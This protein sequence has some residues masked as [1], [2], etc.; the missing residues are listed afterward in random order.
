MFLNLTSFYF[1]LF[2]SFLYSC[3][4]NH[5]RWSRVSQLVSCKTSTW[6]MLLLLCQSSWATFFFTWDS[7]WIFVNIQ[8]TVAFTSWI[9]GWIWLHLSCFEDL[10]RCSWH[11]RC[12]NT[13]ILSLEMYS[14]L[15]LSVSWQYRSWQLFSFIVYFNR[16]S[17]Q[18]TLTP[19]LLLS[20]KERQSSQ[21]M[22]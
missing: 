13:R 16:S 5:N 7:C 12:C 9:D 3:L 6:V 22:E 8:R 19:L 11:Q 10:F 4:M 20:I 21:T 17:D 14:L 2:F 1:F 15:P 18:R